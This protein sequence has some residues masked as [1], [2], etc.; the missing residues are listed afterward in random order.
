LSSIDAW[1]G[2]TNWKETFD[3]GSAVDIELGRYVAVADST[4]RVVVVDGEN[5]ATLVD[6]RVPEA[7]RVNEV[8]LRVGRDDFLVL[9]R[10]PQTMNRGP[11]VQSF[12]LQ[13]SPVFTGSVMLFDR[14]DGA[15]RWS[16]P[17]EVERQAYPI[18]QP[19]DLPFIVFAGQV[20]PEGG[21]T[22]QT[23]TLLVLDKA[24][25]RTLLRKSD[26]GPNNALQCVARISDAAQRQATVE[27][28]GKTILLQFTDEHRPPEPPSLAEVES[29]TKSGWSG[30]G[31]L[32]IIKRALQD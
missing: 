21:G 25:G 5:G 11:L 4:G 24:T 22:R 27:L 31:V 9:A 16:R 12:P 8:H 7:S 29:E 1:S 28:A 15:M 32:G 30:S 14:R 26:L 2:E 19:V 23:S 17:A 3:S 10:G 13:D 6:Y 20:T 18:N